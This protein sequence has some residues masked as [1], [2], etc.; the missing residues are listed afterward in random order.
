MI[1]TA[2]SE[3]DL[4]DVL[5]EL[6]PAAAHPDPIA[7]ATMPTPVGSMIA[8]AISEGLCL[9]E[10][11]GR[12]ALQRELGDLTRL[13]DRPVVQTGGIPA[14]THLA[15]IRVQ[16]GEYFAG[17]RRAFDLALVTPGTPFEQRVWAQLPKIEFGR[18][19]S[20]AD[21]ATAI[22]SPGAFRAVGRA[23]GRN[24]IAIVVPCHRVIESTGALRGYGGGLERKQFLLDLERRVAEPSLFG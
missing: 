14:E 9:L 18:T 6:P 13:L 8:A 19:C 15:A 11:S 10:F 3:F 4:A 24:R 7:L 5:S 1:P 2:E 16:L 23:N 12:K 21:V 17:G 22:G 20:Y